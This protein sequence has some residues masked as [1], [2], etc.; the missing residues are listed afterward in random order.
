MRCL[1][2]IPREQ[3]PA[4]ELRVRFKQGEPFGMPVLR[5]R[6]LFFFV[7]I[8][9]SDGFELDIAGKGLVGRA[10]QRVVDVVA[11][12]IQVTKPDRFA[13]A[14]L[15]AVHR[16]GREAVLLEPRHEPGIF[17]LIH[18]VAGRSLIG[19]PHFH[20]GRMEDAGRV[21]QDL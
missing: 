6:T 9:E 15:G 19:H 8:G 2:L 12:A 13:F 16:I 11:V 5:F 18:V 17:L 10:H 3:R 7:K 20:P 14:L 21:S 1:G 4:D